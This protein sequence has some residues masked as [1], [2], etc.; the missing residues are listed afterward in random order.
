MAIPSLRKVLSC[1]QAPCEC[2]LQQSSV[3]CNDPTTLCHTEQ[4]LPRAIHG[5]RRTAPLT[6]S[7]IA[8][9]TPLVGC[10]LEGLHLRK[11]EN[12]YTCRTVGANPTLQG[13]PLP[14]RN[15][16]KT[17]GT[18]DE[19]WPAH[20]NALQYLVRWRASTIKEQ[21]VNAGDLVTTIP[22]K[23]PA[24]ATP[25]REPAPSPVKRNTN[26]GTRMPPVSYADEQTVLTTFLS[27]ATLWFNKQSKAKSIRLE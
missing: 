23:Q 13:H 14:P 16:I 5:S 4:A 11:L 24:T 25:A 19:R 8:H 2:Y 21:D 18:A 22:S 7:P 3:F 6:R 10:L 27:P 15:G 12:R 17:Y 26:I 1:T 20:P 9:D